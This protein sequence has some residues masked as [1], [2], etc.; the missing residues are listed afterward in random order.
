MEGSVDYLVCSC[1]CQLKHYE[2]DLKLR[3]EVVLKYSEKLKIDGEKLALPFIE[4]RATYT[5]AQYR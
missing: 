4:S 5:F 1:R 2:K 3:Q